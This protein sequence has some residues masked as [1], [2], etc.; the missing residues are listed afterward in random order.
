MAAFWV[1]AAAYELLVPF[2]IPEAQWALPAFSMAVALLYLAGLWLQ[3]RRH[4]RP[5]QGV[6]GG[7]G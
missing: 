2:P 3:L 5:L 4:S 1:R 7:H 6:P